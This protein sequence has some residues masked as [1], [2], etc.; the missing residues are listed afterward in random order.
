MRKYC[1]SPQ[2]TAFLI[3]MCLRLLQQGLLFCHGM[4]V[5]V[6]YIYLST[7]GYLRG[8]KAVAAAAVG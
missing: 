4:P 2:K 3:V 6:V 7:L 1:M 5:P 8:M